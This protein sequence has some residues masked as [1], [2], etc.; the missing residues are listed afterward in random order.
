MG[1]FWGRSVPFPNL[2]KPS[3]PPA[4]GPAARASSPLE[5]HPPLNNHKKQNLC[6]NTEPS[7]K[8]EQTDRNVSHHETWAGEDVQR[9]RGRSCDPRAAPG[10]AEHPPP[11]PL[12]LAPKPPFLRGCSAVLRDS[13][14]E[15]EKT[16]PEHPPPRET[17]QPDRRK[18]G[19]STTKKKFLMVVP[20]VPGARLNKKAA[21]AERGG[22]AAE[23]VL[24]RRAPG[25]IPWARRDARALPGQPSRKQPRALPRQQ[26]TNGPYAKKNT[27]FFISRH[28][29]GPARLLAQRS[30]CTDTKLLHRAIQF[31][32]KEAPGTAIR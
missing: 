11:A 15:T 6:K 21:R 16:Q 29:F 18:Q 7:E 2:V 8:P 10:R 30:S 14:G 4:P 25:P 19:A 26:V 27:F 9:S 12:S 22:A 20:L 28:D 5:R 13:S 17:D 31:A 32:G 23:H 3:T 1:F 24:C